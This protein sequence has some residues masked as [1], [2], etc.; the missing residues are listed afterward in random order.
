MLVAAR[1]PDVVAAAFEHRAPNILCEYAYELATAFTRFYQEHHI[2][3][4]GDA[5]RQASW[6]GLCDLSVR[7]LLQ[8]LD[9][10][11]IGVPERM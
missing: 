1:L 10:L 4:E 2:L 11:G 5:A 9:L 3:S 6:L 7:I 8:V